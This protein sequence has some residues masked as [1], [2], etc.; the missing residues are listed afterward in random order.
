MDSHDSSQ[1]EFGKAE[2]AYGVARF[3]VFMQVTKKL[4]K[5]HISLV[6]VFL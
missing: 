2:L 5:S 3:T 4:L 1:C 6:N